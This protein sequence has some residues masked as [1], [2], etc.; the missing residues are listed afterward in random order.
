MVA[1]STHLHIVAGDDGERGQ[2]D[3]QYQ[4]QEGNDLRGE[5][6]LHRHIGPRLA[7][8]H[9]AG[10]RCGVSHHRAFILALEEGG[11]I[12]TAVD[13]RVAQL[14]PPPR[15]S[16]GDQQF[17]DERDCSCTPAR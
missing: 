12:N 2:D 3:H 6:S 8:G 9:R 11:R 13:A 14:D 5:G 15:E 17:G 16:L 4:Q 10:G 1:I 7:I